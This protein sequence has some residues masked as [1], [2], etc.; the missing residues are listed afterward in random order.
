MKLNELIAV[1]QPRQPYIVN[2]MQGNT[3][4]EK[5]FN[6]EFH[7]FKNVPSGKAEVKEV[8]TNI[9][10]NQEHPKSYLSIWVQEV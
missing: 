7:Y 6:G 3:L 9:D 1:L 8:R 10:F 2:D 5:D 4:V